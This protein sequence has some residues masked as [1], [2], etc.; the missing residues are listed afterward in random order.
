[1]EPSFDLLAVPTANAMIYLQLPKN[2]A[3]ITTLFGK[4]TAN[5]K[6]MVTLLSQ[7]NTKM[8]DIIIT[9]LTENVLKKS[10]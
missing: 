7:S 1:M 8:K 2:E 5:R 10:I 3:R 6:M 9:V 4:P